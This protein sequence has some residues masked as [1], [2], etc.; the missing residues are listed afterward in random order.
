[1]SDVMTIEER[2]KAANALIATL[3]LW[4]RQ[5]LYFQGGEIQEGHKILHKKPSA[6]E[7]MK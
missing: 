5:E 7:V 1:M 3:P 2:I 4:V 6:D